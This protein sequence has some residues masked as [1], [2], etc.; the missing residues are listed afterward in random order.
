MDEAPAKEISA[1]TKKI[2]R[3]N[4]VDSFPHGDLSGKVIDGGIFDEEKSD[5]TD[6]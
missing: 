2:D 4:V 5:D 3:I 1:R 6:A